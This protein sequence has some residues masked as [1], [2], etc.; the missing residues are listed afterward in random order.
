[1]MGIFCELMT[2]FFRM[3][4]MVYMKC[5][6]LLQNDGDLLQIDDLLFPNDGYGLLEVSPSFEK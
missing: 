3:M 5:R 1:M 4:G 2:F 6:H